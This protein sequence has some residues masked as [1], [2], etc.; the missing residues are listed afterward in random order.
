MRAEEGSPPERA[1]A[2]LVQPPAEGSRAPES[3]LGLPPAAVLALVL[4]S[5]FA[6]SERYVFTSWAGSVASSSLHYLHAAVG[7]APPPGTTACVNA[8]LHWAFEL[9]EGR[10]HSPRADWYG[11]GCD[12]AE[13]TPAFAAACLANHS[14]L[15]MGDSITRFQYG[16]LVSALRRGSWAPESP[17]NEYSHGWGSW[18]D[19]FVG[20]AARMGPDEICDCGRGAGDLFGTFFDRPR[21]AWGDGPA[22]TMPLIETRYFTR[23][24]D[25]LRVMLLPQLSAER[26][27]A[28]HEPAWMGVFCAAPPCAQTGCAVGDCMPRASDAREEP[29]TVTAGYSTLLEFAARMRPEVLVYNI[30]IWDFPSPE[31]VRGLIAAIRTAQ[32]DHGLKLAVWKTTTTTSPHRVIWHDVGPEPPYI[33]QAFRDAGRGFAVLDAG[34]LTRDLRDFGRSPGLEQLYFEDNLHY[35][36]VVYTALNKALLATICGSEGLPSLL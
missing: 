27:T 31:Y 29:W 14:L 13:F 5:G 36:P 32:R 2:P 21:G 35:K 8:T 6:F 19:F 4:L 22:Q 7:H 10:Y 34:A 30:G 16:N 26:G 11:E 18:R 17:P 9:S 3:S 12:E 28:W 20:I 25:A 1:P 23:P 15:F 24:R 33:A